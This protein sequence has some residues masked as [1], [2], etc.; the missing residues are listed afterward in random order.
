MLFFLPFVLMK[1]I[2][3]VF[4]LCMIWQEGF[5]QYVY[6]T[7]GLLHMP[8]ADMQRDKTFLFGASYL[9][10]AATPAH[11]NYHTF[12]YYINITIFPWLEI[13]YTCTLHKAEH[14]ST[15][16][17]PSV[18]GKYCNQDRQFS[19]RL[20]IWKEGWWKE[21]T[22]QIV[23]GAN[24]PSTN[25]IL[26]N[27]DKDDYGIGGVGEMGNG[28][29]NRYYIAGT[30]H[31]YFKN[32]GELGIHVAYLYNKRKDIGGALTLSGIIHICRNSNGSVGLSLNLLCR[33]PVPA[34]ITWIFPRVIVWL[35]FR[36]SPWRSLPFRGM[37]TTSI[38]LCGWV[39][40]PSSGRT[41]S[42]LSTRRAPNCMR[43]GLK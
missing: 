43:S 31:F 42:S 18:W 1:K 26:G 5:S 11:W 38:F 14:G 39:P 37:E 23:L 21:W 6:G 41:L 7:T 4:L 30:K 3:F 40:K 27:S 28:H 2:L 19:G 10:V 22:P 15:Y 16:F 32:R 36:L 8:T 24:D 12:N 13:G 20:R 34:L 29:W 35:L 25:D 9:D 17:P 33:M